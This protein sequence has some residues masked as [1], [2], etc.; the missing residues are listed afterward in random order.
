[1]SKILPPEIYLSF[2]TDK[3]VEEFLN[4]EINISGINRCLRT[5]IKI[6]PYNS[7]A[8][9]DLKKIDVSNLNGQVLTTSLSD[10]VLNIIDGWITI[11]KG[12]SNNYTLLKGKNTNNYFIGKGTDIANYKLI[13]TNLGFVI[14]YASNKIPYIFSEHLGKRGIGTSKEIYINSDVKLPQDVYSKLVYLNGGLPSKHKIH[15]ENEVKF[16]NNP[17]SFDNL[18]ISLPSEETLFLK[19]DIDLKQ[20]KQL[21]EILSTKIIYIQNAKFI[22]I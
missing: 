7:N 15:V 13:N 14:A 6:I 9:A 12:E 16:H 22:Q 4:T 8:L 17:N 5:M 18:R 19:F 10:L 11:V 2:K 1:L 3:N 21:E 20:N